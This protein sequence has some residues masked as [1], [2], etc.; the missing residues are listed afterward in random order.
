MAI[1]W[2][3]VKE[4]YEQNKSVSLIAKNNK[5]SENTIKRKAKKESWTVKDLKKDLVETEK[6][7]R[8]NYKAQDLVIENKS[9]MRLIKD[10]F[11]KALKEEDNDF[12]K[13]KTLNEVFEKMLN[14]ENTL[15]R[16]MDTIMEEESE[17]N[18]VIKEMDKATSSSYTRETMDR[19]KK[20]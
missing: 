11:D 20:I 18:D 9:N 8:L 10:K 12:K 17:I 13:L 6:I 3:K 5:C 1:D 2:K 14:N 19:R 16:T 4:E 15:W 7:K